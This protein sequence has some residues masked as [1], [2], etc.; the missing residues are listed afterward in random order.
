[1]N[2]RFEGLGR[3][4]L[5]ALIDNLV[6]LI[7]FFWILGPIGVSLYDA[8]PAVGGFYFLAF[9]SAWFN[10]FALSEW[11]WGQTIG[12]NALGM[13]VIS[14]DRTR[15]SFGQAS[16]RN[17]LRL[18]D[19]FVIGWVMIPATRLHQRLGDKAAKTVVMREAS[20]GQKHYT[21]PEPA[22]ADTNPAAPLSSAPSS[23]QAGPAAAPP[24]AGPPPAPPPSSKMVGLPASDW[25]LSRTGWGLLIGL[26][27]ALFAPALV[28]PF[29]PELDSDG[30][31]LAAQAL[32]GGALILVAVGVASQW[33]W[34]PLGSALRSLGLRRA[35]PSDFGIALLAWLA[36]LGATFVFGILLYVVFGASAEQEDIAGELGIDDPSLLVVISAVA[37][38]V[39]LAPLSEELFFRGMVYAG[40]R[41]RLSIWPAAVT[42]G[43]IFGLPHV[44][45][46]P[47]A[48]IPLALLGTALAWLYERTGSIW[49]CIFAHSFNNSLVLVVA[50]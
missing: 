35:K 6:W 9:F 32:F 4:F 15:V 19:F 17:L 13:R 5:A 11:R 39:G 50:T 16:I 41:T 12:K 42:S 43:V 40:L 44:P 25:D 27:A 26:V 31:I 29:D 36:Y 10:Y 20:T 45:T 48:A 14:T 18:I 28:L 46:G 47:L 23:G 22:P 21:V 37:L 7:A 3:R 2:Q 30:G 8:D 33:R 38:L 49:P 34:S 1:M 24:P